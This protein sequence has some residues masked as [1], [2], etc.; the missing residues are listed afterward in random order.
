MYTEEMLDR[1]WLL[2]LTQELRDIT[3]YY[4]LSLPSPFLKITNN[5]T[6]YGSWSPYTRTL[7]I[8]RQL[9]QDH[10]WDIVLEIFKHELAHLWVSENYPDR[11]EEPHGPL[12]QSACQKL[13]VAPWARTATVEIDPNTARSQHRQ[14]SEEH[15]RQVRRIEKLL[16][17]A[18]SSNPNEAALAMDR[19]RSLSIEYQMSKRSEA[20]NYTYV[21][22]NLQ[23]KTMPAHQSAIASILCTHFYVD[24][25]SRSQY[26]AR[27][28]ESYKVLEILGTIENVQIAE[29]IFWYLWR[30]LPLL[31]KAYAVLDGKKRASQRSFYLGVLNGF[32]DK[33]SRERSSTDSKAVAPT[34]GQ[35]PGLIA[36]DQSLERTLK[37][38]LKSFVAE[39]FPRLNRSGTSRQGLEADAYH[40]GVARGKNLEVRPGIST[41]E[42]TRKPLFLQS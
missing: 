36:L 34:P 26:D 10:S 31:W 17:L 1:A 14:L 3:A 7:S 13:G 28:R 33:L 39:R 21:L 32:H 9:I 41:G 38:E 8:S 40:S 20:R 42:Q 37:K 24:C 25:V 16:A 15:E 6:E 22:I 23:K 2:Q 35:N 4:N 5:K 11:K 18:E 12:F 29:Y 30:E 19:A 27:S